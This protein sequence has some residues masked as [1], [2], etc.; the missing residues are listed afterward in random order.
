MNSSVIDINFLAAVYDIFILI[1]ISL[2][3]IAGKSE[4][5]AF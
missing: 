5:F 2:K 3:T 4:T 1:L